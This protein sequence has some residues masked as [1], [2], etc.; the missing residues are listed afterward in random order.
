MEIQFPVVSAITGTLDKI[1]GLISEAIPDPDKRA[2]L[3]AHLSELREQVYMAELATR[4]IPWVDALHKMGRQILALLSL[5]IPAT[6]L[7]F[8]PDT[9]AGA[10]MAMLAPG[11]IYTAVKGKGR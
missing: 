1:I 8:H 5:L 9:D 2:Q 4:T 6:L 11:G 7:W 3:E 10:L